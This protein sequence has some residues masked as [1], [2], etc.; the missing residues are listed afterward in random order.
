[1]TYNELETGIDQPA[2]Q[3][4]PRLTLQLVYECELL[5]LI[6]CALIKTHQQQNIMLT[7]VAHIFFLC[8]C[9][10]EQKSATLISHP[11]ENTA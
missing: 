5:P 3:S 1:M 11:T 4:S 10:N 9:G 2:L 7:V 8:V 6:A